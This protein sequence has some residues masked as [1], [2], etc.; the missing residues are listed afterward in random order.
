MA[1]EIS[2]RFDVAAAAVVVTIEDALGARSVHTIHVVRP[3]GTEE[4]VE[5]VVAK[6]IADAGA[7]AEKVATAF[8]K[9]GWKG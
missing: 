2:R 7:R 5:G 6:A 8:R 3:D 4:D 1:K 9:A